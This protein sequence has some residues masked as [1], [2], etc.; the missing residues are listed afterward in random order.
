MFRPTM[1]GMCLI[2]QIRTYSNPARR[3][4]FFSQFI[5][6]LKQD[7]AKN[8]EM[9]ESLKKFREEATKLEHS[10]ALQK[11]RQKYHTVESEASKG[12]EV[13]KEHLGTIKEKMQGALEEGMKSDIAKKAGH[14]TGYLITYTTKYYVEGL[15]ITASNRLF[16]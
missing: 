3:P 2:F 5:D 8:K 13:F 12:S 10:E 7:M 6:N 4:G 15:G 14:I 1:N 9:K 16:G 11:A